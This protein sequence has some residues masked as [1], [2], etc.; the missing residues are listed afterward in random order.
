MQPEPDCGA[1]KP[2]EDVVA[3][4]CCQPRRLFSTGQPQA[5]P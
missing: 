2:G 4:L 1:G 3:G 5:S